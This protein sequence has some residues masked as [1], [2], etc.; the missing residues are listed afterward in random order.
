MFATQ[1][2]GR[3][4]MYGKA[5]DMIPYLTF[6]ELKTRVLEQLLYFQQNEQRD[7]KSFKMNWSE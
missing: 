6:H 5:L 4:F 1:L 7:N 3:Q 2:V